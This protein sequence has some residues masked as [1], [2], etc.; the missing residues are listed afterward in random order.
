MTC[1]FVGVRNLLVCSHVARA[2]KRLH[3]LA[4][5]HD[6][7]QKDAGDHFQYRIH[8]RQEEGDGSNVFEGFPWVGVLWGF[9][10][11][12]ISHNKDPQDIHND[13]HNSQKQEL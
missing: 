7:D 9:A 2:G 4:S 13:G 1:L 8:K 5:L 12:D 11:P 3:N 10:G 6:R